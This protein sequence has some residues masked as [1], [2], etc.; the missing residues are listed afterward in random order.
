MG[1]DRSVEAWIVQLDREIISAFV[2]ALRPGGSD[3]GATDL[4]PVARSVLVGPVSLGNDADTLG[5]E[6]QGD[7]FALEVLAGYLE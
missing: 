4:D 3:L 2:G 5:L 1:V 7:D 6:A